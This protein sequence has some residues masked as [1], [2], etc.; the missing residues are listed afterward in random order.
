MDLDAVYISQEQIGRCSRC[1][2][3]TD[4]R[5]G[6]CFDC[7]TEGERRAAHRTVVQHVGRSFYA[8]LYERDLT[9]ARIFLRWAWERL[10]RT[11]D[12]KPGGEFESQYGIK[13]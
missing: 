13:T 7:A 1:R 3:L 4:L 5:E 11:G 9:S 2:S 12:Y 8:A 10:T 6:F